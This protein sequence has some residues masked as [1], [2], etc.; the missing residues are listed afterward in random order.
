MADQL[1]KELELRK[2]END[3]AYKLAKEAKES[4]LALENEKNN[5]VTKTSNKHFNEQNV[6]CKRATRF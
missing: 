3:R 5:F 2:E 1:P 6:F 4:L